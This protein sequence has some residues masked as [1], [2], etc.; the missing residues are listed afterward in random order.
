M[1]AELREFTGSTT[2]SEVERRALQRMEV[3]SDIVA[4]AYLRGD[5]VLTSGEHSDYYFDKYLFETKPTILRRLAD[6]LA[7]KPPM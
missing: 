7:E 6:M 5:F 4:A 1:T 3:G 2:Q